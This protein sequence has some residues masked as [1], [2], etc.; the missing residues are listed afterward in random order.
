MQ[1][2]TIVKS[3]VF[4][5]Q[6]F[7]CS[8]I[9]YCP[10]RVALKL[11]SSVSFELWSALLLLEFRKSLFDVWLEFRL[12]MSVSALNLQSIV[13]CSMPK[14]GDRLHAGSLPQY[15]GKPLLIPFL[16]QLCCMWNPRNKSELDF[17]AKIKVTQ[18]VPRTCLGFDKSLGF[19]SATYT[20]WSVLKRNGLSARLQVGPWILV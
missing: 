20:G 8:Q 14:N 13:W 1:E 7:S 16:I 4:S 18:A 5:F 15:S 19:V 12:L 6:I 11:F 3:N 10:A 17:H 2:T 9:L